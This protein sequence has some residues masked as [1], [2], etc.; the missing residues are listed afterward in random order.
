MEL[1]YALRKSTGGQG[2]ELSHME[3][4]AAIVEWRQLLLFRLFPKVLDS[5]QQ[6]FTVYIAGTDYYLTLYSIDS[7]AVCNKISLIQQ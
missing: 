4:T 1:V 3:E 6:I 7:I 5:I 2:P